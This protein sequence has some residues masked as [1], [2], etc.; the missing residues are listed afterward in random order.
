MKK[1]FTNPVAQWLFKWLHPDIAMRIAVYMST[2]NKL[3]SGEED[4]KSLGEG[5]DFLSVY[6]K[7]QLK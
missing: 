7:A 3:I 1:L 5:Q 4:K 6:Q 2:K